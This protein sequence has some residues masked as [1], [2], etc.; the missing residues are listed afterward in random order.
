M[1]APIGQNNWR[2]CTKCFGMWFNGISSGNGVCPAGGSHVATAGNGGGGGGPASW[3]CIVVAEPVLSPAPSDR[4]PAGV[5]R[6]Q[7]QQDIPGPCAVTLDGL[8]GP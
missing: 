7:G 8:A 4:N 5:T 3:D 6:A 1:A 2:F